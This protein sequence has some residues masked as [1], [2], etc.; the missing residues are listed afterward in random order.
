M[1]R[2]ACPIGPRP[3]RAPAQGPGG[4][5]ADRALVGELAGVGQEVDQDLTNAP[6][7]G[8]ELGAERLYRYASAFGFGRMEG[9]D[10]SATERAPAPAR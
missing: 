6:R 7:I 5:A 1:R 4:K 8:L 2:Q 3:P 10:Y 9:M